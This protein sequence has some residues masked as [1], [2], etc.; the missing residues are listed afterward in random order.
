META[1]DYTSVL[2]SINSHLASIQ[3]FLENMN[4]VNV[5]TYIYIILTIW[6]VLDIARG[7]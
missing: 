5:L 4:L 6:L 7:E 2:N 1:N 3:S